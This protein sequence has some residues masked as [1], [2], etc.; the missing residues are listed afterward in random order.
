MSN[1][2]AF[3]GKMGWMRFSSR[4]LSSALILV[5][6]ISTWIQPQL[7]YGGVA[8]PPHLLEEAKAP[9][10]DT[11]DQIQTSQSAPGAVPDRS[12][13]SSRRVRRKGKI[14]SAPNAPPQLARKK[15]TDPFGCKREFK[16]KEE[17]YPIDSYHQQDA[18]KLRPVIDTVPSAVSELNTYQSNRRA[19]RTAAYFGTFG[20]LIMIGGLLLSNSFESE[21]DA[22]TIRTLSL[23]GGLGISAGSFIYS[24]SVLNANES[25]LDQA[26]RKYNHQNPRTPVELQFSTGILF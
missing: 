1:W 20:I 2:N 8:C 18:E 3:Y 7:G 5:F 19:A 26:V 25:H 16:Y 15:K 22:N 10:A 14:P 21:E 6:A 11:I 9:E 13:R 17:V 23:F 24:F 12:K 4:P